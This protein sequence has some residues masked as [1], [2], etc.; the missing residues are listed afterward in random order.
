[1]K[2]IELLASV[3]LLALSLSL[4]AQTQGE[5]LEEVLSYGLP[6]VVVQT[7]DGEEPTSEVIEHP[8]GCIGTGITNVVSKEARMQMYRADT[9]WYDSGDYIDGE[10][11]LKIRHRGNTSAA[12]AANK[13]FKLKLQK[14]ADLI[15]TREAGDTIDRRSKD[16]VLLNYSYSM[17]PHVAFKLSSLMGLEYSPRIEFV[18][19]IL[20]GSY[21]GLY[22]L[23]ENISREKEGRIAVDKQNGYII[24]LDP[25]FWNETLYIKSRLSGFMGWTLK[26]P[27]VEDLTPEQEACIRSDIERLEAAVLGDDYPQVIDV[28]SFAKWIMVHDILG[29][30]DAG[31][32]NMYFARTDREDTSLIRMPAVWDMA[33]S[34]MLYADEWSRLHTFEGIRLFPSL[35]ANEHCMEFTKAYIEEWKRIKREGVL[36][37][38]ISWI[39]WFG[40]TQEARGVKI[41]APHHMQRWNLGYGLNHIE[42]HLSV[43]KRWMVNRELWLDENISAMESVYTGVASA[44]E[45]T[46]A[47]RTKEL[48]PDGHIV[49]RD[50]N[51]TYSVDGKKYLAR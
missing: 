33:S 37:S 36:D 43:A 40:T 46:S 27:K 31:G 4:Q 24:E 35:F 48:L 7:V 44:K 17:E 30:R 11:G 12:S 42:S 14:K 49:I 19:V 25:Y 15:E 32:C 47:R 13:P 45:E 1:M 20:N 51:R 22:I 8:A 6:V 34:S 10:S 41:S 5:V 21:H 50:G 23:G 16:W 3:A 9:L 18:N 29:T 28:R 2:R 39:D 38:L 26:Y